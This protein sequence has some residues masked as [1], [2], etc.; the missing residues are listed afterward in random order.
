MAISLIPHGRGQQTQEGI[1]ISRIMQKYKYLSPVLVVFVFFVFL[2]AGSELWIKSLE[3]RIVDL[4]GKKDVLL[5]LAENTQTT[6][7]K[8]FAKKTQVLKGILDAR[9][10]PSK[11]FPVFE[12]SIHPNTVLEELNF[13]SGTRTAELKGV[14]PTFEI[15][16]QQFVIWHEKSEFV[17]SVDLTSFDKNTTGQIEFSAFLVIKDKYLE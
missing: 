15:L 16:G 6:E 2:Y 12:A 10:F 3:K 4:Q 1:N 5:E 8:V 14:V 11:L 7:I 13:V 17:Q 9:D